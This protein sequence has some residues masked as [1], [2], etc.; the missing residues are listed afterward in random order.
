[1]PIFCIPKHIAAKLKEAAANGEI[2]IKALYEMNSQQRNEFWQKYVNEETAQFINSG[3]EKSV[4]DEQQS[5][6]ENWVK[7]T[8]SIKDKKFKQDVIDKIGELS[9]SGALTP[10]NAEN[11]LSDLVADKLGVKV[12]AEEAQEINKRAI[13][14]K[15]L[16]DKN[17]SSFGYP[18][19]EYWNE[20]KKMEKYLQSLSPTHKLKVVTSTIGRGSLL[21]APK[22]ALVNIIGNSLQQVEQRL[23]KRLLNLQFK[24]VVD[25]K[26]IKKWIKE[27]TEIQRE[28]GFDLTR[29]D[30]FSNN[31]RILGEDIVHSEGKGAIRKIGRFYEDFV[32]GKML[33]NPDFD[34]SKITVA[35]TANLMATK[36]AK[37]EGLSG[38]ELSKKATE[39]FIDAM[40]VT[41][42]TVQGEYI[43]QKTIAD[44][45]VATF[46]NDTNWTKVS[47]GI[48]QVLNDISGDLRIGDQIIKF[49]KT[50]ANVVGF[51][52]DSAGLGTIK[53]VYNLPK[54]IKELKNGEP[55]LMKQVAKDFIR[56]GLGMTIAFIISSLID[57]EDFIGRWPTNPSEQQLI[58]TKKA[59]ENSIRVGDKWISLDYFGFLGGA[60]VG[61]L[62]AK[63]Y[64]T[65]FIGSVSS[66]ISGV[67]LQ[68]LQIP[69]L[70][71]MYNLVEGI[72]SIDP[73]KGKTIEDT[74]DNLKLDTI[75]HL[76]GMVIPSFISDIAKAFDISEREVDSK[77]PWEK[78]KAGI[79]G[80][81][82]TLR[83][84]RDIFGAVI[85][86]EP[87]WSVMLFGARVQTARDNK[88]IT[89]IS[90]LNESGNI[91]TLTRPE[92]SAN[93]RM[94]Q[95]KEQI[96]DDK[97][98]EANQFFRN[99]YFDKVSKLIDSSKYKKLSDDE[100]QNEINSIRDEA[101]EKTLSK[102]KYKK[103]KKTS[104]AP[105]ENKKTA[106]SFN[107]VK[108]AFAAENIPNT[109][110]KMTWTK[111]IRTGWEKFLGKVASAI[112]GEQKNEYL[113]NPIEGISVDKL[114]SD[115][116]REY[117]QAMLKIREENPDW[118]YQNIG[119]KVEKRILGFDLG[120][121]EEVRKLI[122]ERN[123]TE[124]KIENKPTET[125]K[126]TGKA[127]KGVGEPV[128]DN[129]T[130]KGL[131]QRKPDANIDPI[132]KEATK[133]SDVT[134]TV[135][136]S[137]LWTESGY[138][139]DAKNENI[140]DGKVTSTDRGIAQINDSAH[141]DVTEEQAN[142]PA[143]AI[144]YAVGELNKG[145][146]VF[147]GD[148]NETIV[149]YNRGRGRVLRDGYLEDDLGLAYLYKVVKNMDSD[150]RSE[151]NIH[152]FTD[153]EMERIQDILD[154]KEI[155]GKLERL[156]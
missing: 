137:L 81:R 100:K 54:A 105:V 101:I 95:L 154:K 129:E 106:F 24:G 52:I 85:K 62:Y 147:D 91:P 2:N 58:D 17:K 13:V 109:A 117:Y 46:Q 61:M 27:V 32:F 111:D 35:D 22:S 115:Q 104:E 12:T 25:K 57:P 5:T 18:S 134:P 155:Y 15:E 84:K 21:F 148:W 75:D 3:F 97:Y 65:N 130:Y 113:K 16:F 151:L 124:E 41:P 122:E 152:K 96:G 48:R 79:P 93:S 28:S 59:K 83:E 20:R 119:N 73:G 127:R 131:R 50:P 118:Y 139:P 140:K 70:E 144:P 120:K 142:D 86:G 123:L 51:A 94:S 26:I 19:K 87:W 136:S 31:R 47:L 112:P 66:Y 149:S 43:R 23:E 138:K 132:I 77:K 110:S 103:P 11:F 74:I 121:E 6:L 9:Q 80:L 150:T 153:D 44:A 146:K 29:M 67:A 145:L 1:M 90:R 36:L 68:S 78:I 64:G 116:K 60:L 42:T 39:F 133:D 89:E 63:K 45:M 49:A 33:S 98:Y 53:G 108:E 125:P 99:R 30:S 7:N 114:N 10:E 55:E 4:L 40:S 34:F 88:V 102:Y 69:G 71:E 76:K 72:R 37:Q 8:F 38:E 107:L 156:D 135:I 143:F 128:D 126:P 14:L 92:K 82:Q 56:S 141:P